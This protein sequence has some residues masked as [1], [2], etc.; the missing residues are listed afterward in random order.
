MELRPGK[1]GYRPGGDQ[2]M[3]RQAVRIRK[4]IIERMTDQLARPFPQWTR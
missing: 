3:H 2:L 1:R 4:L